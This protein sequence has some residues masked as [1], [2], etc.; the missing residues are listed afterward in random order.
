MEQQDS[1]ANEDDEL[2]Q[3][4]AND[5]DGS[6]KPPNKNIETDFDKQNELK[7]SQFQLNISLLLTNKSSFMSIMLIFMLFNK[8][9]AIVFTNSDLGNWRR[10]ENSDLFPTPFLTHSESRIKKTYVKIS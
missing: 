1:Y 6:D 10:S 2:N 5:L 4:D 7:I 3:T 8:A 9:N